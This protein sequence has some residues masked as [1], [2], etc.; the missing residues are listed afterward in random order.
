M[1]FLVA[2]FS[3]IFNPFCKSFEININD[4]IPIAF[5]A[6][7]ILVFIAALFV[8]ALVVLGIYYL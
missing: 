4:K 5:N 3:W 7:I 1:K 6:N 2:L 8:T